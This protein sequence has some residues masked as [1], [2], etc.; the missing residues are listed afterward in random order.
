MRPS[1]LV[2]TVRG[3]RLCTLMTGKPLSLRQE[4]VLRRCYYIDGGGGR[5]EVVLCIVDYIHWI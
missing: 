4:Y 1:Y 3:T 5:P 2:Y